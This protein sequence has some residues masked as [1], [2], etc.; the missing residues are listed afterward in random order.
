MSLKKMDGVCDQTQGSDSIE[1]LVTHFL[2]TSCN[3][4]NQSEVKDFLGS[5]LFQSYEVEGTH[6]ELLKQLLFQSLKK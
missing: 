6:T 4:V 1:N 2:V 5:V 3:S